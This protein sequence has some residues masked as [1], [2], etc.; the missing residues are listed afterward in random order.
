MSRSDAASRKWYPDLVRLASHPVEEV[1]NTDAWVMGQDTSGSGFHETL[2][3][4][5]NDPSPMV[6]VTPH[7]HW[8]A[9]ETPRAACRLFRFS[10]QPTSVRQRPAASSIP[11]APGLP[12]IR[13][14]SSPNWRHRIPGSRRKS[15]P[16]FPAAS[17]RSRKPGPTSLPAP[18]LPS[19]IPGPTRSGKLS[20]HF[21]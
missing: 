11:T 13:A 3:K 4:M 6:R 1:R 7:S 18:R 15:A 2:L 8:S 12:S 21:I 9:S 5:L 19:S 20:A 14:D 10:N 17:G 16:R